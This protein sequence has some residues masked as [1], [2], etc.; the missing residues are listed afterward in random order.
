[1]SGVEIE[2]ERLLLRQWHEG[3][4]RAFH[5]I[6][7]D[8]RVYE[9]LGNKNPSVEE[10]AYAVG[11]FVMHW[12]L[13][14][15]GL[16]AVEE[17]ETGR[18]IGRAGLLHQPDWPHG[19]EK[20]EV[21]WTFTPDVWGRGYAT[22]AGR[23]SLAFGFEHVGLRQIFS[24]TRPE[25]RRSRRVM[26]RCGLTERGTQ[27]FYEHQQAWYAIDREDWTGGDPIEIRPV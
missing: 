9:W 17:R 7:S 10:V 25:N 4:W 8:P 19:T 22:E 27:Y 15:Y 2:T 18:L 24:M 11:R 3:E 16:W 5:P 23:A 20:V 14:G 1:M 26:E 12:S 13:L 6:A 21:G